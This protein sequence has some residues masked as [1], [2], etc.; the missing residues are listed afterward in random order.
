MPMQ[1]GHRDDTVTVAVHDASVKECIKTPQ[2]LEHWVNR[3]IAALERLDIPVDHGLHSASPNSSGSSSSE[4]S[5][6]DRRTV[7]RSRR[8]GEGGATDDTGLGSVH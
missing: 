1:K 5:E 6:L 2:C 4:L 3:G 7:K 8:Q